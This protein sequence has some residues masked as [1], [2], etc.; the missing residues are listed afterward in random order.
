MKKKRAASPMNL[1]A[2]A[3]FHR[4][5]PRLWHMSALALQ[6]MKQAGLVA[7]SLGH[8]TRGR[9]G[10]PLRF[11]RVREER[12]QRDEGAAEVDALEV[13]VLEGVC[14]P[15]EGSRVGLTLDVEA[16][17]RHGGAADLAIGG[18][19]AP[20]ELRAVVLT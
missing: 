19:G 18:M 13:F 15:L 4:R 12:L 10:R 14:V 20:L 3:G 8:G 6:A 16:G 17:D 5:R 9:L 2:A 11:S 1:A 7:F